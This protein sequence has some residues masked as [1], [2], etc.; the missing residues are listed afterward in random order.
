MASPTCTFHTKSGI[1]NIF[2]PFPGHQNSDFLEIRYSAVM[3]YAQA[4]L[5]I[6]FWKKLRKKR[7]GTTKPPHIGLYS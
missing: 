7:I 1:A 2:H 4:Q 5:K 6:H 3:G